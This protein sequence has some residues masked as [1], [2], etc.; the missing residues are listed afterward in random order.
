MDSEINQHPSKY[1]CHHEALGPYCP[2]NFPILAKDVSIMDLDKMPLRE[3]L[4][5]LA[6]RHL[7]QHSLLMV[8]VGR[9]VISHF[10]QDH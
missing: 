1:I 6:M 7:P 10:E 3:A 9:P 8:T 4:R 5:K 2:A